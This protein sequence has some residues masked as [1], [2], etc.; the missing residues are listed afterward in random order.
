MAGKYAI[1][2]PF[3][4]IDALENEVFSD[5]EI[6]EFVRGVV[7]YHKDGTLPRFNDRALNLL[8][9]NVRPEFDHNIEKYKS[10]V[11]K[12]IEAGKQ[13]GAPKG[14]KNAMGNRGGG[15]PEGNR[16]A[17]KHEPLDRKIESEPENKH[18]QNKQI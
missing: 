13:G 8:F 18:K 1:Y 17:A 6:G 11:E 9:S 10:T 5:A 2:F 3:H 12:R 4:I 16:N 7:K 14:N 15:A